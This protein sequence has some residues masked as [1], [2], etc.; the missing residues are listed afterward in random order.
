MPLTLI[1]GVLLALVLCL[2]GS[3]AQRCRRMK[4]QIQRLEHTAALIDSA[5]YYIAYDDGGTADL[6]ANAAAS[7]MLGRSVGQAMSKES[8]HDE[9]G[10]RLLQEQA[11]PAVE[12]YGSWVG[13]NKLLHSDGHLIDVQQFIFPVLDKQGKQLGMSTLMRDI[14]DEK[15][16][17]RRLD[18]QY[19][20]LDSSSS[21]IVALDKDFHVV[22]ANPGAYKISGYTPE[23]IGMNFVPEMFHERET[24]AKIRRHWTDALRDGA[25]GMESEFIRK[26]GEV[27]S[28][29]HKIF[30]I[31]DEQHQTIGIGV[32]LTDI[33]ELKRAQQDLVQAKDAAEAAN[34]AKSAFLSNM[35]HEI[36]T[37]MNAI[38]G[39]TRIAMEADELPKIRQ[40]LKKVNAS[41]EHLLNVINDVLDLS[42]IESGKLELY[43]TDFSVANAIQGPMGI[44]QVKVDEKRQ[45]LVT[46]IAPDVPGRLHGDCNRMAQVIMNLLSNAVKFT[47]EGG[48]VQLSVDAQPME[49][50]K[51]RLNVSVL[52]SGIG[53]TKEQQSHLFKAFEQAD[54]G[55]TSRFG[56]TGLGLAISK[57]LV[58]MMGGEIWAESIP[59][60]GS[61]FSFYVVFSEAQTQPEKPA[62]PAEASDH[63]FTGKRILLAEDIEINREI[64]CSLLSSTHVQID[65]AE[66]GALALALFQQNPG[67]FDLIFMDLQMPVMDGYTATRAIR[68]CSQNDAGTI[69]IIPMTANAFAED[70]QNCLAAGM[71]DHVSKP[72]NPDTVIEKM[73]KYISV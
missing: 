42:K 26:D 63:D 21:F 6:Y 61:R 18:I 17:R 48:E 27:L 9:A 60:E 52:D 59:G 4:K 57:R 70:V 3:L 35:S 58:E 22:Y 51:T 69:P 33:T 12:R 10:M 49:G 34:R 72:I 11:F 65:E 47:K 31:R 37:P 14:T 5:P 44:I 56:G 29:N 32:I 67:K 46:S 30:A 43:N 55:I 19:A 25:A 68:N 23:E 73:K 24:C 13:E 16:M 38:I 50:G 36:R 20:I 66:N 8:T 41:S 40:S 39:M 2:A 15:A 1:L 54:A 53:M 7:R 45:R 62:D 71:N 28:V 64:L